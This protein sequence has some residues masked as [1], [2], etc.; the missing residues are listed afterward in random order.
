MVSRR[1]PGFTYKITNYFSYTQIGF[2]PLLWQRGLDAI[3]H[4]NV[5]P[6]KVRP[7]LICGLQQ[8]PVCAIFFDFS[9]VIPTELRC[10]AFPVGRL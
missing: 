8:G 3:P 4:K 5:N 7:Q 6:V 1:G 9:Y 10:F 2:I